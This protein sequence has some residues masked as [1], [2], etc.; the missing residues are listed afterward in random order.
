MK[1]VTAVVKL[2]KMT[3]DPEGAIAAAAKLCY[4][5]DVKGIL[6][7][8]KASAGKF[9]AR[10]FELGHLSPIEHASF[11]FY[12]EGVSRAMTH[13]LV[14]HRIASYSQ[15]SQRYVGHSDFDY[16][17]PPLLQ[18]KKVNIDGHEADAA[19]YFAETM[20]MLAE[21]YRQLNKALGEKGEA[22]N[23]DARYVLP[24]AC[25]TKI[26]VTMNA[27]ELIHFCEER[28]CIRAQWEIRGV[29]EQMLKILRE[30]CPAVFNK[31]GPKCIRHGGCPEGKMTCGKYRE[32]VEKYAR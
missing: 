32:M 27:R 12:V 10:L 1:P 3:P 16:V 17:I 28:L 2:F 30:V 9:V 31:V 24:N 19:E 18:G 7:Q 4:A 13:Q 20:K 23:E 29:A 21:R 8:D 5:S 11:T 15:R 25:E 22:S 26:F 14:R 6:E